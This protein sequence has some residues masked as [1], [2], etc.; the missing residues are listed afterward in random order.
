MRSTTAF[1][2]ISAVTLNASFTLAQFPG[3]PYPGSKDE[4]VS[5]LIRHYM[6]FDSSGDG[7]ISKSEAKQS[8]P[9]FSMFDQADKNRDGFITRDE[10]TT[11]VKKTSPIFAVVFQGRRHRR[12]LRGEAMVPWSAAP[13][14]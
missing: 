11:F 4:H 5:M 10:L 6:Q 2:F 14:A 8:P 3:P 13:R 7:T 9:F 1:L 12:E